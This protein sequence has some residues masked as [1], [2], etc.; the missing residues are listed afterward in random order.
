MY[1]CESPIQKFCHVM[2]TRRQFFVGGNKP[3]FPFS[4]DVKGESM[5]KMEQLAN[6]EAMLPR[7]VPAH[8]SV[9]SR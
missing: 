7:C 8:P 3:V 2:L 5:I 9:H 1:V 6:L 4:C